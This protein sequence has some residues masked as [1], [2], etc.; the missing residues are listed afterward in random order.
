M[1]VNSQNAQDICGQTSQ[2][3]GTS[4]SPTVWFTPTAALPQECSGEVRVSV[5]KAPPGNSDM[6][7]GLKTT[8]L[9]SH[10]QANQIIQL[11][12]F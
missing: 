10:V 8:G 5:L 6:Q 4:E 3:S 9:I 11:A 7:P 2:L 1:V 12:E